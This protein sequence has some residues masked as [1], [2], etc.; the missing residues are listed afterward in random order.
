MKICIHPIAKIT[1][2][3]G[4]TGD[5]RLRPLSRYFEDHIEQDRLMLGLTSEDSEV[6]RL[7]LISGFGKARRFKFRGV[8]NLQDANKIVG[9]I[10]YA[11]A[12][13]EDSINLISKDL[14]G[15]SILTDSGL[16]VGELKDV[17]WL[18]SNDAYVIQGREKEYLIP[19]I[20]EVIK[21]ID[22][23]CENIIISPMDG[24]LD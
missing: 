10:L 1:K 2:T 3:S 7:E 17:M 18:P 22:H 16:L 4:L 8:D 5:V 20:P 13:A 11:Q 23:S 21:S 24:L 19:I 12:D 15:Y 6:V 14:L 9:K